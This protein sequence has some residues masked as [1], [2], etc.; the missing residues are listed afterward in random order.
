MADGGPRGGGGVEHRLRL[1]RLHGQGGRAGGDDVGIAGLTLDPPRGAHIVTGPEAAVMQAAIRY[2][3]G[4]VPP[5]DR[6]FVGNAQHDNL[7]LNDVMFYFLAGRRSGTRYHELVPGVATTAEVQTR[8]VQDLETHRVRYV[9][10]RAD[11]GYAP[12]SEGGAEVL[13]RF[14]RAKFVTLEVFGN[15]SVWRKREER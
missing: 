6:I 4:I 13:D 8:I 14:I 7:V 15:Y 12:S 1:G 11:P 2:V 9:V 5:A 3:E 10:L